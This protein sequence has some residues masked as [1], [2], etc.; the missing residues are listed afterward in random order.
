MSRESPRPTAYPSGLDEET[1]RRVSQRDP[2]AMNRFFGV[3]FDRV[4]AYAT[5]LL[6]DA[7]LAE[8]LTQDAFVRMHSAIDRLDPMRDPGPWVFTVVT[9][10]VRDY[11]RSRQYRTNGQHVSLDDAWDVASDVERTG[12]DLLL[13]RKEAAAQVRAAMGQL[14]PADREILLLRCFREM[15]TSDIE[16]VLGINA[17]AVRQRYS[18]AVR[19]LGVAFRALQEQD[20]VP[21]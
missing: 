13:E 8:D 15:E 21:K 10:T 12:G 7:T 5:R 3:F 16:E 1:L 2:E 4:H 19:R 14:S 18:R 6:R 9:N 17:D 20:Q 11:W